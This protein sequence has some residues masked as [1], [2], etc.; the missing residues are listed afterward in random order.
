MSWPSSGETRRGGRRSGAKTGWGS[1]WWGSCAEPVDEEVG[2]REPEQPDAD[3]P[4]GREE[5]T[6]DSRQVVGPDDRVLVH[7]HRCGEGDA[8][9]PQPAEAGGGAEPG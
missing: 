2:Q 5:R 7:E 4:V 9:P 1:W 8:R 3:D 6:V